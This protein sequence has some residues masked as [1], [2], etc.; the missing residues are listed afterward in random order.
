MNTAGD[1]GRFTDLMKTLV[2]AKPE[3]KPRPASSP[4]PAVS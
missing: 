4:G 2:K 3:K 1:F